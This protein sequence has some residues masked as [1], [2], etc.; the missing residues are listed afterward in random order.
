MWIA[1]TTHTGII[2]YMTLRSA[3]MGR[4]IPWTL[5]EL[6]SGLQE[7]FSKHKR[8]PT[9]T[10]VDEFEYL[11]SSRSI[12][13]RFG[14][15]VALRTKLGLGKN[16]DFRTG[17]H[18]AN[19]ARTINVRA[20]KVEKE[21]YDF[22]VNRFG[23]EF[24]HREFFFTDDHR[25]RADFF[26]F[27]S[28]NG[29]CVDVFY[30]GSIR[31]LTGCLNIKINKYVGTSHVLGYPVIFLQMNP[32]IKDENLERLIASKQKPLGANQHLM[33]WEGFKKFCGARNALNVLT[34]SKK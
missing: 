8:Y 17:E 7:F 11:P 29:F 12:E 31:N 33:G 13:R 19:R 25:T 6:Q 15:L 32:N 2:V 4:Q 27:D 10:E 18:S 23:K 9:A 5:E 22:L 20:H 16:K 3:K 1:Y 28:K 26:I 24:V 14:G 21:V 34:K 30:A